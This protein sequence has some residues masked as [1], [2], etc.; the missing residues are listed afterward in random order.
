MSTALLRR[1]RGERK[2]T[3]VSALSSTRNDE[4]LNVKEK[5]RKKERN[6]F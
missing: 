6:H 3:E 5:E 4:P 1:C 2:L